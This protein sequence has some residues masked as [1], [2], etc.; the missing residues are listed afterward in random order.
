MNATV[1]LQ[2]DRLNVWVGTQAADEALEAA[3]KAS[4]LKPEQVYVHNA[5]VGGGFGAAMRVTKSN[6]PSPLPRPS[7]G[8]SS[9]CGPARRIPARTSSVRMRWSPSR[10]PPEA[11]VCRPHGRCA[12]SPRRSTLPSAGC[13]RPIKSSRRRSTA[14][15]T[16]ATTYRNARRSGGQE[17]ALAGVVLRAPGVNQ[18]VFAIE[19]FLDEIAHASGLDPYQMRRKLLEASPTGSM[20]WIPRRK[21]AIGASRC[22]RVLAAAS[23]SARTTTVSARRSPR[24]PSNQAAR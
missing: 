15:S 17:H 18:H 22:R 10:P 2:P 6:K 5:F 8:R 7:I 4:G 9:W 21:R 11:T 16:T 19:S 3:A 20:Y 1:H 13:F 14:W 23:R 12:S 24:L